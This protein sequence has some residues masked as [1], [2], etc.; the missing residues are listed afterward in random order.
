MVTRGLKQ[1]YKYGDEDLSITDLLEKLDV[2]NYLEK[3]KKLTY[4][5]QREKLRKELRKHGN[6]LRRIVNDYN[7]ENPSQR[8][9]EIRDNI[10]GAQRRRA[11]LPRKDTKGR[12]LPGA[13]RPPRQLRRTIGVVNIN[14]ENLTARQALERYPNL[15]NELQKNR[16]ISEKSLR[17]K[18]ITWFRKNKITNDMLRLDPEIVPR[19]AKRLLGNNVIDHYTINSIGNT[20]P[21]DFLNYVRNSV[22]NHMDNNRQNKVKIDLICKMIR[23][24]PATGI[25]TNDEEA[26]FNSLQESVFEATN[27]EELY[28]KIL[29]SFASCLKNGS[30]WT[31]KNVIGLNITYIYSFPYH[32]RL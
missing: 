22:I 7:L 25:V 5:S 11:N 16:I 4:P 26:S 10:Y 15:R 31:L 27:L 13:E 3:G 8:R 19:E 6:D 12:V 23:T 2:V 14:G 1:I 28:E 9:R 21:T 30:G 20:S 18:V 32:R 24:D 29:E 17:A